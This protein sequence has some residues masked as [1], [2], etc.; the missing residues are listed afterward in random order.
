MPYNS[1]DGSIPEELSSMPKLKVLHLG[2]NNFTGFIPPSLGNISGL[3]KLWL[4]INNIEGNIPD[5]LGR[6]SNLTEFLLEDNRLTG[7][8]PPKIFNISSLK[9]IYLSFNAL[10]GNLPYN[11]GFQL[12]NL[13]RLY[14]NDNQLGGSIPEFLSNSSNLFLID[15][16]INM[17]TGP[18]PMSLGNLRL[19]QFFH[20]NNNQ[21]GE[22]EGLELSFLTALTNCRFLVRLIIESNPL[23]GI[24]P[25]SI[26]N[27]SSSLQMIV[28][29]GCQITGSIPSEI[30]SLKNLNYLAFSNNNINGSIPSTIG[31]LGKLQR[32]YLDG[33]KIEGF[34][35]NELCHLRNL[36]EISMESN[37]LSGSIPSCIGNLSSL[38]KLHLN[39]NTLTSSIP[40]SLWTLKYLLFLNLSSNSLSG[41]LPPDMRMFNVMENMDI[42]WNKLSG[43][44]PSIVDAFTSLNS[45]NL[46]RNTFQGL[47]PE[48]LGDLV[49]L[50]FMDLSHNN[51][52]GTIPKSLEALS[53]LKHLNFSFN[54]LSGE[55]PD[56]GA[57]TNCTAGSFIQNEALCGQPIF[58]VPHCTRQ[59]TSKRRK[60]I[61][62]L[63]YILPAV[64]FVSILAALIIV[65]T[66]YRKRK[67]KNPTSVD[68]IPAVELRM[69]SFQELRH[70]TDDFSENKSST[71]TKTLGTLGY[72][73]PEYGSE[74]RVSTKGDIYSYGI[75]LVETFTRMKPT[76]EIFSGELNLRQWVSKSLP[77]KL[78]EV[79]DGSLLRTECKEE[80]NTTDSCLF[81]ILQLGLECSEEFP[82]K[83][84]DIKDVIFKLNKIKLQLL[85]NR[86]A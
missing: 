33:N 61:I 74:G 28:A 57:F 32:L 58:Q 31:G 11:V 63:K 67:M 37:K 35:P 44:I 83:R 3:E 55:I 51:L 80:V 59:S 40:V 16:G 75:M 66:E 25:D 1:F 85:H 24:L 26:G 12:P 49:T 18:V 41:G 54:K 52:S 65:A 46:S 14:M 2:S 22:G 15:L 7:A 6:L 82:D 76:D 13:E 68:L 79:L 77:Y 30:G 84:S 62:L 69:I 23:K 9:I 50:E 43:N 27:L 45:L 56:G 73:A 71:N 38:K 29:S 81:S 70:A 86:G 36:G 8:I 53:H 72:I 78:M 64:V 47:I 21:L 5:E 42:S 39:S 19:L 48:S 4:G 10:F 20:I 17:L 34:I 60:G